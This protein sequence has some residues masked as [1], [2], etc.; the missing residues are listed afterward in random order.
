[1]EKSFPSKFIPIKYK[2]STVFYIWI[3]KTFTRETGLGSTLVPMNVRIWWDISIKVCKLI[4]STRDCIYSTEVY[5]PTFAVECATFKPLLCLVYIFESNSECSE[6]VQESWNESGA[7]IDTRILFLS[8]SSPR[9]LFL[10][11]S[12]FLLQL[13]I[14]VCKEI[15]SFNEATIYGYI[16]RSEVVHA[17]YRRTPKP[18]SFP[19]DDEIL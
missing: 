15:H 17:Y 1:M 6:W 11:K 19:H 12:Q 14:F 7:N 2:P 16:D 4:L 13:R 18:T 9:P 3:I 5:L 10:G 8:L